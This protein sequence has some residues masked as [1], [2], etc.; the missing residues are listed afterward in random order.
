MWIWGCLA[1]HPPI[2]VPAVGRGREREA[3]VTLRGMNGLAERLRENK[4][5]VLLVLSP[6]APFGDGLMVVDA[7]RFEG[8]L[9]K[10]GAGGT[11]FEAPGDHDASGKLVDFLKASIPVPRWGTGTF[12]LDHASVV[13]LTWFHKTWGELPPLVLANPIG[14]GLQAAFTLGTC[15]SEFKDSRRWALLASGDLSHRVTPDAPAG[16]HPDGSRFDA[17]VM[18][19]IGRTDAQALLDLD[20]A[21][22][23]RAGEC[24]LRSVITLLG[25]A[26]RDPIEVL[27]YEAPFGVGYGTALWENREE[28]EGNPGADLPGLARAAI[29]H[30]LETGKRFPFDEAKTRFL[31][32]ELWERRRACFVSLKNRSDGTLRGCIGTLEPTCASLG[33]E[34]L[35]NAVSSATRDPRFEPVTLSELPGITISVDVLASPEKISGPEALDPRRYG[36]IVEKENRRGVLL[37]DLEGIDTIEEQLF[38]ASRKAGLPGPNGAALWRFTVDR[39]PESGGK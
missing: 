20:P 31:G 28:T 32:R 30:Y 35:Q 6:H 9:Q 11:L 27:S 29:L 2:L 3:S 26:G 34:I 13:P 18:D 16:Y 37:P 23:D 5:D 4:P 25:L 7:T 24:G 22:V 33:E 38:I 19:A 39:H 10:F 1:P 8:G 36:V 15:L 12:Q 14:L 21:F 17:L